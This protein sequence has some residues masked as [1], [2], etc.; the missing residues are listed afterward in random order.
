M[1]KFN[2]LSYLYAITDHKLII[3]I[4]KSANICIHCIYRKSFWPAYAQIGMLGAVFAKVPVVALTATVTEQTKCYTYYCCYYVIQSS[5]GMVDSEII[6]VNPNRQN[7][8]YTCSTRPH[9]GD[10]KIKALLVLYI[11]K[12]QV[13]RERMLPTVIPSNL[14][15]VIVDI[16]YWQFN[17][18][19]LPQ[20]SIPWLVIFLTWPVY[21]KMY[22][23]YSKDKL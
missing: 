8:F 23:Y 5:L 19:I 1:W 18:N 2:W 16:V 7:I 17:W 14:H 10:D 11:A 6:A 20:N 3:I 21:L 9:T 13:M 12:L 22:Y 15:T 4:V